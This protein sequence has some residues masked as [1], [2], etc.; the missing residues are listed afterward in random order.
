MVVDAEGVE[1]LQEVE[2]RLVMEHNRQDFFFQYNNNG[3]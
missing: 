1:L 2:N 3:A